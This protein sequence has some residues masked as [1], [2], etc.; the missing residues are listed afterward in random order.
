MLQIIPTA[1]PVGEKC[2]AFLASARM[3]LTR[4]GSLLK[5]KFNPSVA[6][7]SVPAWSTKRVCAAGAAYPISVP[8]RRH[9]PFWK[10]AKPYCPAA[11]IEPAASHPQAP[12]SRGK[13]RQ[14]GRPVGMR[15][16]GLVRGEAKTVE[17]VEARLRPE[18]EV[19]I[20]R[21]SDGLDRTRNA[22]LRGP[23]R[24]RELRDRFLR[25]E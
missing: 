15:G 11:Q 19:P 5:P 17:A 2:V 9:L 4:T 25:V 1:S 7:Q 12:V 6:T 10:L 20:L 24:V 23:R 21:L 18:P 16:A 3:V 8:T 14:D 22:V 13:E